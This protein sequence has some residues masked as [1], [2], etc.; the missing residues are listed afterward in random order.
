MWNIL[1]G[2]MSNPRP[3]KSARER[4]LYWCGRKMALRHANVHVPTSTLI[5]PG[6]KINPRQGAIH[7]G[8]RCIVADGAFIQGCVRLGDE[9]SVQ[10]YT[11][12]TGY[13]TVANP[14]GQITI[15][16]YVRIASHGM[17]IGGNHVFA[18]MTQPIHKQ[19]LK[20]EPI[21][22]EDDIWIGGGVNITAGVTIG[23]GSVVGSGSVV[24]RSIPA[25][26]IAAGVPARV[27][28][29]RGE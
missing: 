20:H 7:F 12:L 23:Q 13:G 25:N 22:L 28:R 17:M 2:G 4:L 14:D 1:D 11:I 27:I 26:S 18:D 16:N 3:P 19:G 21:V 6:A 15:G 5:H 9:C 10:A 8:E 24:T 29:Q